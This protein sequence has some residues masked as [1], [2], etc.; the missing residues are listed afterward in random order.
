MVEVFSLAVLEDRK[1]IRRIDP[2]ATTQAL[3]LAGISHEEPS[4]LSPEATEDYSVH[5]VEPIEPPDQPEA[6]VGAWVPGPEDVETQADPGTE[7]QLAGQLGQRLDSEEC[8]YPNLVA[9]VECFLAHVFPYY[10]AASGRIRWVPDW[11]RHPALVMPLDAMWRSYEVSRK[12]PGQ[13]MLWYLQASNALNTVF[14]KNSGI[15][16]SL[17]VEPVATSKGEPLP[18]IRPPKAWRAEIITQ[19]AV[20]RADR[21]QDHEERNE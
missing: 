8:Y 2:D 16:G 7:E 9:F 12:S 15:V 6:Y 13:M 5:P 4:S 1:G 20:P 14:D 19:L 17:G 18:C 3:P 10:Q 11:W 21:S